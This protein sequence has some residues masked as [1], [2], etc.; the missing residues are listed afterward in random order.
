MI[1]N[2]K[3]NQSAAPNDAIVQPTHSG[4]D[5][6]RL[7]R[8]ALYVVAT[9]IGNLSDIS[10]R[11]L[12]VLANADEIL[13]EDTRTSSVLLRHFGVQRK[14]SALHDFNEKT[15]TQAI[16]EKLLRGETLA[17]ISDAG[18]PLISDPGYV[19]VAAAREAS[20]AVFS[21]PGPSAV[22]AALSIAGLP[23]D[24]FCFE[25]FLPAQSK[26]RRDC[27][28]ALQN[29]SRTMVFYESTH[30]IEE[31]LIDIATIFL[32]RP[33]ALAKE[34]TKQFERV[35]TGSAAEIAAKLQS[36]PQIKRGEFVLI[37]QGAPDKAADLIEAQRIFQVLA[38]EM[39]KSQA[40]KLAAKLTGLSRQAIYKGTE[41]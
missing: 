16:I 19:L 37:I 31:C 35:L 2:P 32:D 5:H 22:V 6:T 21:I 14:L 3:E 29:E 40:A 33:I 39:P 13:C 11:A 38:S 23:C 18:T 27:L 4:S 15:K 9:P 17:L 8:G 41:S 26:A 28:N 1:I 20:V 30:R 24:R 10:P 25:G 36:D 12:E 7:M 34:L